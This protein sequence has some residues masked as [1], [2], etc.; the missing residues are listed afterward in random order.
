[1]GSPVSPIVANIY[2]EMFEDL[3]LQ[4]TQVPRIWKRYVDDTFCVMEEQNTSVFLD[5]LNSLRPTILFTMELEKDGSL[6]FL[7][8]LLTRRTDGGLDVSVYRKPT[9]TDRYLHYSSH[10]PSYVKRSVAS[11]LFH[12]ART[13][14]SGENVGREERHL[15][16][17]LRN[18]GYPDH[19]ISSATRPSKVNHDPEETP[20]HTICLPYVS[21]LSEELRRVCRKFDIRTVFKTTATLRQHL[22]RVKDRDP[23]L[24]LA[25][26]VYKIPCSCGKEYIGETK[27]MLE[28]RLKEHKAATRRGEIEKSA[29]AEHAWKEDHPPLWD[30][31]E[32]L[33]HANRVDTLR[34]KEAFCLTVADEEKS[35]NRDKGL[36]TSDCWR[37]LLRHWHNC[38]SF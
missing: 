7:D 16:L 25:G 34:I 31:V 9:H 36:A 15:D 22:T 37:P 5:H 12:R 29:V 28:T 3:A 8:T 32:I 4:R 23:M 21:G 26:V 17:V 24:S 18:N 19:V 2:M 27:R 20:K 11:S 14:A 30:E 35:L 10:H 33:A 6:P 38:G 1:M 13:I